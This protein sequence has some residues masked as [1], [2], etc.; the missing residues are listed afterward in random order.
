MRFVKPFSCFL[1]IF[2]TA[3]T[4]AARVPKDTETDNTATSNLQTLGTEELVRTR[5]STDGS[6][7]YTEWEGSVY[8]FIPQEKQR[9]LFNIIGMNVARCLQ[10]NEGRWFLTSRELTFYLDP[11]TNQILERWQNPWTQEVVPVVHVANNPVQNTLGGKYPVFV[12]GKNV[13]FSLDIP[14]TYP[15]VLGKDPKFQDYSPQV[16]YQ[17]GEFFK[18]TVPAEEVTDT[19][20]ATTNSFS[21]A[22]TRLGP[23]LPWMKMGDRPGQLVYSATV[24]KFQSF[25]KLSPVLQEL[26]RS[27]LRVYKEAPSCFLATENETSWTYF[28]KHFQKYLQGAQF[29][30]TELKNDVPC[31][32]QGNKKQGTGNREM[33]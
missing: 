9:K 8:A 10:N 6:N 7:I 15:N 29:P 19:S 21:G 24:R 31:Q 4:A 11:E 12:D 20:K 26:I 32:D 28:R 14:L 1:A 33:S 23:W 5:C 16:L 13:T 18:F 17:A 27:R 22:W 30:I 2:I 25:E 3:G